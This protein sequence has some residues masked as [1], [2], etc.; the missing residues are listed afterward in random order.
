MTISPACCS[1]ARATASV[2]VPML[3]KSEAW[4]G[5]RAAATRAIASFSSLAIMRRAS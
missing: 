5:M 4:S 1:S 2:V 3:M